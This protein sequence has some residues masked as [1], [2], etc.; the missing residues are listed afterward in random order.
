MNEKTQL[1]TRVSQ[2]MAEAIALLVERGKY[3][4][5][6]DFLRSAARDKLEKEKGFEND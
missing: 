3:L 2:K 1:G 5:K 6:A 4:N